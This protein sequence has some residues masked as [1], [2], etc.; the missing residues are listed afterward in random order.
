MFIARNRT[1]ISYLSLSI[2]RLPFPKVERTNKNME[3]PQKQQQQQQQ[4]TPA[5]AKLN[6]F[7]EA[8]KETTGAIDEQ[9]QD[10]LSCRE[11]FQNGEG[12]TY[13]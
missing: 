9:L 4:Q 6:G 8:T 12:L 13:K 10:G 5:V 1:R 2:G 3:S 11:L 7:L